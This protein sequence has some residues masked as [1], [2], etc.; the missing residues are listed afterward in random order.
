MHRSTPV[1]MPRLPSH[2]P[3]R[4]ITPSGRWSQLPLLLPPVSCW[5]V[6]AS[7]LYSR[8][9][10]DD[11]PVLTIRLCCYTLTQS[12]GASKEVQNLSG[13][14][15]ASEAEVVRLSGL[16]DAGDT[17]IAELSR[18]VERLEA[19]LVQRDKQLKAVEKLA[20]QKSQVADAAREEGSKLTDEA[21]TLRRE[22]VDLRAA[23]AK[24]ESA[25]TSMLKAKR[26]AEQKVG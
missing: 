8:E 13:R 1:D 5:P 16:V 18:A 3:Y 26:E 24:A 12:E 19:D 6:S 21:S 15:Q 23:V 22:A 9:P 17:K 11:K 14:L 20:L 7:L 2:R 4:S 25:K 10:Q